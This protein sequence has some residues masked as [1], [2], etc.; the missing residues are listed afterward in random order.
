MA[1][2]K[3]K[4]VEKDATLPTTGIFTGEKE[5]KED[6]TWEGEEVVAQSDTKLEQDT[7]VGQAVILRFFEFGAN[8]EVFK[9]HK[10]TAQ[11]LFNSHMR[12][13]EALLWKD[14]LRRFE[15]VEPRLMFSRDK[16]HY[17]F[18]I[19]CEPS[20]GNVLTDKPK[21]LSQLLKND[22][23]KNTNVLPRVV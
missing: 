16:S 2:K 4:I 5:K 18:I 9:Q 8:P 11:E 20:A 12:G 19:A 17:R 1:K 21:T 13:I 6:I 23:T 10:P 7:G 15:G 14:G 22:T 3:F